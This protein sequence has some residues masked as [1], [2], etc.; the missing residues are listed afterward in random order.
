MT[1]GKA[2]RRLG[3]ALILVTG[4]AAGARAVAIDKRWSAKLSPKNQS[5]QAIGAYA[6]GCLQGA[7]P[8]RPLGPGFRVTHLERR[9]YFGHPALVAYVRRLAARLKQQHQDTLL[10]GDMAQA[11]GGPTP[12]GHRSHQSGLDVDLSY[13]ALGNNVVAVVDLAKGAFTRA[14][15]PSVA[16][17]LQVAA[18]DEAV[19]RIFVHP[20]IKRALCAGP[21]RAAPWLARIRPWWGHHDHFHVRL[22]C[23]TDSP[24][25][26]SKD[27]VITD[28]GCGET[29]N[30]WF[31]E[32]ARATRENRQQSDAAAGPEA[33]APPPRCESVLAD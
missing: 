1:R 33:N 31:S 6:N 12:T 3:I 15:Q 16:Q 25:C 11:R 13:G 24:D 5:P 7:V 8:L 2:V 29:L 19:D 28:D 32:D 4:A 10:V 30:W 17:R 14:W 20:I 22:R 18:Q 23:P 27:S 26:Q 21:D 9:R